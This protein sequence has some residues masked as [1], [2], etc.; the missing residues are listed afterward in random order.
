MRSLTFRA[1]ILALC[2]GLSLFTAT[3]QDRTQ[4]QRPDA[5]SEPMRTESV[6]EP[7]KPASVPASVDPNSYTLGPDDAIMLRVWREPDLSGQ[8]VIRPDGKITVPLINEVTAAGLTPVQLSERIAQA[9]GKFVNNPQV[10]V[11][12]QQVRSKRYFLSGEVLRPGAYPIGVPT[13]VFEALTLAGGFREFANK[14]NVV[15][16]RGTRRFK[17]NWNDAIKGKNPGQNIYL[18]NG[19]QII[20]P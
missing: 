14:K 11:S 18:E 13:T 17:F 10:L 20:V 5:S 4:P 19:D 7:T 12:V 3:P 6:V 8:M 1:P 16:I 9:L 2:L 15:I